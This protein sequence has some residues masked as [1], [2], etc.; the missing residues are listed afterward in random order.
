MPR[1]YL[2]RLTGISKHAHRD[3][4]DAILVRFLGK[5]PPKYYADSDTWDYATL[6]RFAGM[7]GSTG[8]FVLAGGRVPF[9]SGFGGLSLGALY[10]GFG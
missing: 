1:W 10:E 5:D 3:T 6:R 8:A 2:S 7:N 9:A 4:V